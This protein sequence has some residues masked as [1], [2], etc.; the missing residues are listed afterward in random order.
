MDMRRS[1]LCFALSVIA[2]PALHAQQRG[3]IRVDGVQL[4]TLFADARRLHPESAKPENQT[5]DAVIAL[6]Y[7]NHCRLVRH[8]MKLVGG[9]GAVD[10]VM[11]KVL[12]DS[13]RLVMQNFEISGFA[14]FQTGSSKS[15]ERNPVIV[16][17]SL[18]PRG[19]PRVRPY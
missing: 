4:D 16:W 10:E 5:S 17:G 9:R 18:T 1:V 19:I 12:P 6:V 8:G 15:I 13:S 14:S 11:A 7:D 3:C 2:L